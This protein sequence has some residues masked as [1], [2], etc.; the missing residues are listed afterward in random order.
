MPPPELY[1][2]AI[3]HYCEK[4]RFALDHHGVDYTLRYMTPGRHVQVA[5]DLGARGSSLPI[6]VADG[7]V[8]QGSA[9]IISWA[10]RAAPRSEP[11]ALDDDR[12]E[13][14]D[15]EKRLD[16]RA[17]VHIRR[18]FYSEVLLDHPEQVLPIFARDIAPADQAALAEAW[19]GIC[20][21][22]IASMNLGRAQEDESKRIVDGE[23]RWLDGLL[24]DG[25]RFLVGDAFSRADITAASLLAGLV[26]PPEHPAVAAIQAPPRA[27]QLLAGWRDRPTLH[28][29]REI[30]REYR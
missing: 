9:E 19:P 30:Y 10:E 3:S 13:C 23:V 26:A 6:L 15:V 25:R 18:A 14:L 11:S 29:I 12:E 2:F 16:E 4:A 28:W 7:N 27:S 22:M 21:L 17:G 20:E 1:V 24:A 5:R 8:V